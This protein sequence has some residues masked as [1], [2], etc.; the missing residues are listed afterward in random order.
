MANL[1]VHSKMDGND[2]ESSFQ[3]VSH[4]CMSNA[5]R[6]RVHTSPDKLSQNVSMKLLDASMMKMFQP[7]HEEI[8]P[9]IE[10]I[11]TNPK[12]QGNAFVQHWH[13]VQKGRPKITNVTTFRT[14]SKLFQ[15][16][17]IKDYKDFVLKLPTTSEAQT[18]TQW[19]AWKKL[20]F[21]LH[22]VH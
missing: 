20:K 2:D 18:H 7:F 5:A 13:L 12:N 17:D 11:V 9:I 1:T 19:L 8:L 4:H 6:M 21:G 16:S 15:S 3:V 22:T 14:I 10:K